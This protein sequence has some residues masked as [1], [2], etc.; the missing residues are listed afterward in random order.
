MKLTHQLHDVDAALGASALVLDSPHSGTVYPQDF[1]H[2]CTQ[3][4]L[5]GAED[6]YVEELWGFAPAMG[7]SLVQARFSR[8]YVDVNRAV[9]EIDETLL[10]APWPGPVNGGG[11]SS[12]GQ[13]LGVAHV[14]RRHPDLQPYIDSR[15]D[16]VTY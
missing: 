1:G 3:R 7:A 13:R 4:A 14:G 6:T 10:D 8:S 2:S 16:A 12:F 5:R 11:Q 9:D 15:R